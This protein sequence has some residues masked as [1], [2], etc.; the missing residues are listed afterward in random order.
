M[1]LN[2]FV[3][4]DNNAAAYW[5]L[6]EQKTK[7]I[8]KSGAFKDRSEAI[9]DLEK[10]ILYTLS[11]PID[12]TDKRSLISFESEEAEDGWLWSATSAFNGEIVDIK[13]NIYADSYDE[14]KEDME[15]FRNATMSSPIVDSAGILIPNMHFSR[16]FAEKLRPSDMHNSFKKRKR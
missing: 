6:K 9:R 3:Y 12:N 11:L 4:D 16:E 1:K 10:S 5:E 8:A 7:T 13:T 15:K 2:F 14:V